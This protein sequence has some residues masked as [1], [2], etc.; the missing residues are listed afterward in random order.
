MSNREKPKVEHAV[1]G[2]R[3]GHFIYRAWRRNPV[4]GVVERPP[5]GKKA[6]KIWV[7]DEAPVDKDSAE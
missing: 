6:F 3:D 1:R 7:P 5:K 4:T 2:G